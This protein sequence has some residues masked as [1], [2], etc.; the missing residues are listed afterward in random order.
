MLSEKGIE[1]AYLDAEV[2]LRYAL[3]CSREELF[4]RYNDAIDEEKVKFYLE[5]IE[6]RKKREPVAYIIGKKEFF[7]REFC[8]SHKV[9]IPRPETETVVEK[10]MEIIA[11]NNLKRIIDIGTGSGIIAITISLNFPELEIYATDI[12]EDALEV[13]RRNAILHGVDSRIKFIR[14]DLFRQID[15]EMKFDLVVSN[16]P[17]IP[18]SEISFLPEE[19]RNYEPK[20]AFDGGHD[21]LEII[22]RIARDAHSYLEDGGFLILEIGDG[23]ASSVLEILKG[24]NYIDSMIFKDLSGKQRCLVIRKAD[25]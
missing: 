20:I 15:P 17:Y 13:A 22:R 21:G 10:A 23:Q 19:I 12:S 25:G 6:R 9:M 3:G 11:S 18:T 8:V 24:C 5:I 14:S 7:S 4:I 16:P 2:L 1:T